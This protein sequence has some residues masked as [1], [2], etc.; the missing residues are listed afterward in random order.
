M[1]N[2]PADISEPQIPPTEQKRSINSI[3]HLIIQISMGEIVFLPLKLN[4]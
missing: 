4:K 2:L 1:E 3:F